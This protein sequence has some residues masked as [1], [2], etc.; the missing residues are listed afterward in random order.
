MDAAMMNAQDE[1]L[2]VK[3]SITTRLIAALAFTIPLV[4]GALSSLLL[5]RMFQALKTNETA[6][7][8]AVMAGMKEASLPA[9]V[10][11][12]LAAFMG[13]VLVIVLV[14]RMIVQTKTASPPFW[15]FILGGILSF[16]PAVLF[17]KAQLLVLE[18]LSPGSSTGSAGISGIAADISLLLL[19]SVIAAPVVFLIL[20]VASVVPL[21]SRPGPK[22]ISLITATVVTLSF[23]ATAIGI[24]F[25][26]DGPKR[27]NEIVSLPSNVKNA[28]HDAGIEKES[29]MVLTITA[30]GKLYQR[31]S[32]DVGDK[33]ERTETVITNQE[34]PG[35]IVRSMEDK[36]PDRRMVY[37]K[38]DVNASYDSVL[39]IFAAIRKADVDKIGLVVIGAKDLDDPY[40]TAPVM[41]EVRLQEPFSFNIVQS[42][43]PVLKKDKVASRTVDVR[44]EIINDAVS[45][46]PNPLTLIAAVDKD[47]KLL[48]NNEYMGNISDHGMKHQ[49]MGAVTDTTKLETML[50]RIFK[51]RENNGVFR[52]GTN[53]VEKMI[54]IKAS[55]STKY[56]DF[57]K[58]VEALKTSGAEPIGVQIDNV[59]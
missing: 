31:L 5:M 57:I 14:V 42:G 22:V 54:Y 47:G 35:A 55:K 13:L 45:R 12:Y 56:G 10:S 41:Y 24:P 48:L 32:R 8:A 16:L 59:N 52:E 7:L 28:D 29:S 30:D 44:E 18:V 38:C 11:L 37:F 23:I 36:T 15:F 27:K 33:V 19:A 51:E 49:D 39:K 20:L 1:Q 50:T 3:V 9:I 53:E 4:G 25:L 40:Q 58:L 34:L 46:K 21:P 2:R 17:W 43:P 6:G 26:I